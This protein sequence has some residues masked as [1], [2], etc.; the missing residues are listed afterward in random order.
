MKK[1][2]IITVTVLVLI[3]GL[4]ATSFAGSAD[5]V[6]VVVN[7]NPVE[8]DGAVPYI[9][10]AAGRTMVPVRFVSEAMGVN[11]GWDGKKQLVALEKGDTIVQMIIDQKTYAS[12]KGNNRVVEREMDIAPFIKEGTGRTIVPLRFVSEALGADVGWD[13]KT[14][15]VYIETNEA[16]EV[17]VSNTLAT[18]K[19]IEDFVDENIE[20]VSASFKEESKQVLKDSFAYY[21]SLKTVDFAS[22]DEEITGGF[23]LESSDYGDLLFAIRSGNALPQKEYKFAMDIPLAENPEAEAK[24]ARE[25]GLY[26]I[27]EIFGD[28]ADI[29]LADV[30]TIWDWINTEGVRKGT[31]NGMDYYVNFETASGLVVKFIK[32]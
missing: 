9:D 17:K 4:M 18:D 11:V 24:A 3:A 13:G 10:E 1:T 30:T 26:A 2:A 14:Y 23:E 20:G 8:F 32:R 12:K 6:D 5:N 7:G 27:Q 25:L 21:E 16:E 19:E 29:V 28:D 15:T 31:A 22:T